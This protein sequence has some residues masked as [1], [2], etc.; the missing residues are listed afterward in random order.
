MQDKYLIEITDKNINWI[1]EP[2][3]AYFHYNKK[4]GGYADILSNNNYA[5]ISSKGIKVYMVIEHDCNCVL[6]EKDEEEITKFFESELELKN[7]L[8]ANNYSSDI[9]VEGDY[10]VKDKEEV[11][12]AKAVKQNTDKG[13]LL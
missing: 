13:E 4:N 10:G 8:K 6:C 3:L 2:I 7:Y 1:A 9:S 5:F 11:W 12:L